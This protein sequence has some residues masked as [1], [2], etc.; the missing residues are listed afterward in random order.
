MF[1]E[2]QLPNITE[3]EHLLEAKL[4]LNLQSCQPLNLAEVANMISGELSVENHQ[5]IQNFRGECLFRDHVDDFVKLMCGIEN[6]N[7]LPK[8]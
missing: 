6:I 5:Q 2:H 4:L 8:N 1:W 7:C 3:V